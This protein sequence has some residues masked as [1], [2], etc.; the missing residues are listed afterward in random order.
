MVNKSFKFEPEEWGSPY[1]VSVGDI[2]IY[3]NKACEIIEE[4]DHYA[5][6]Q[7]HYGTC[8]YKAKRLT[9]KEARNILKKKDMKNG[10]EAIK[11]ELQKTIERLD[12]LANAK[13]S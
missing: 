5:C 10:I 1:A 12:K 2:C 11:K 7:G 8:S 4:Y 3:K 13:L 9:V 6:D